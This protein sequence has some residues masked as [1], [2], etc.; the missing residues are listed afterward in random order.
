[1][2]EWRVPV[3]AETTTAIF[4]PAAASGR[5][6][7]FICAHGAGG[8]MA[9][10]SML[11]LSEQLRAHG[12]D[13]VRF[14]FL[15]REKK[16][17]RPDPM[18]VLQRCLDAVAGYARE[19]IKPQ[20]LIIGGRSMGGRAASMMAADGYACDGLLLLA[21]PLHPAGKPEQ[22][23]D[24]HLAKIEVPTLCLNGTR[25]PL[26]TRELMERVTNK[27]ESSWTVHWLEGADHSFH[28]LK[29]SGRTDSDVLTEVGKAVDAWGQAYTF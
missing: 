20:H 17:G 5:G 7:L 16:L 11:A 22:L 21:Y 4:E 28:V 8:H 2:T 1:M 25:D 18:P 23:R 29:S 24:A 19:T 12:I 26:C 27:L 6:T 10:R 13:I 3:G 14:N 9:D 15:Y